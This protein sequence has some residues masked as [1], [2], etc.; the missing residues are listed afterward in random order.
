MLVRNPRKHLISVPDPSLTRRVNT[1][2][3]ALHLP[4]IGFE[5]LCDGLINDVVAG[6]VGGAGEGVDFGG[7]LIADGDRFGMRRAAAWF[8]PSISPQIIASRPARSKHHPVN[9]ISVFVSRAS[10]S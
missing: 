3:D 2:L 4:V 1:G 8:A 7:L 6:A 10:P 5:I 9:A